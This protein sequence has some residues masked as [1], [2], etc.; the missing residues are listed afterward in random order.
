MDKPSSIIENTIKEIELEIS[1]FID[2]NEFYLNFKKKSWTSCI[3]GQ[4]LLALTTLVVNLRYEVEILK[5]YG[6]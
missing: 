3:A 2:K 1:S 5:K 6:L 4:S